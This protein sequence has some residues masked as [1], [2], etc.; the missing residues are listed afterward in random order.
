M[1]SWVACANS[2]VKSNLSFPSQK[3]AK[4]MAWLDLLLSSA[5][6]KKKKK[7]SNMVLNVLKEQSMSFTA[8]F[9]MVTSSLWNIKP[10]LLL[11]DIQLSTARSKGSSLPP[12]KREIFSSRTFLLPT[13]RRSWL[14][15]SESVVRLR[16][17]WSLK[18]KAWLADLRVSSH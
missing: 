9:L 16:A 4:R 18:T 17:S 14:R 15:Y 5:I 2:T 3:R 10:L 1:S 6:R 8:A 7:A 13:L 11:G 12:R